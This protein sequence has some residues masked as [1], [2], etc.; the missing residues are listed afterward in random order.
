[1]RFWRSV[2][3]FSLIAAVSVPA[4]ISRAA[5]PDLTDRGPAPE[6]TDTVWI[7]SDK[8]VRL[9]DLRGQVVL[10]DFWTVDCINCF[11]TQPYLRDLYARLNGKG[12]QIVGIHFP[13]FSYEADVSYVRDYMTKNNLQYPVAIDNDGA[14]WNAYE[15][16][17]WPAVELIDKNGHRRFRQIGEGNYDRI[18]AAITAL[19]AE[20]GP[21]ATDQPT[22]AATDQATGVATAAPT[23]APTSAPT[24]AATDQATAA[25]N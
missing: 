15:M 19:L 14:S 6:L 13:E 5:A 11:H 2:L 24:S 1:M 12:V 3:L 4:L 23:L 16:H 8:P 7:N 10:L 9:A 17:A 18:D 25:A 22:A 20:P 21:A